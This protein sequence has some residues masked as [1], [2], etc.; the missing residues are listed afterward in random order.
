MQA[1]N[2]L[3]FKGEMRR[4]ALI[5]A[6]ILN[7]FSLSWALDYTFFDVSEAFLKEVNAFRADPVGYAGELGMELE[8]PPYR[9][10]A[11]T[12]NPVL[13]DVAMAHL[14]DM[15]QRQY[16]SHVD[17]DGLTPE[18]RVDEAGV[19]ALM[20]GES[21]G[22]LAF[23]NY[24]SPEEA[25]RLFVYN[26]LSKLKSCESRE[27]APFVFPYTQ[28]GVALMGLRLSINGES[29]NVYVM[30]IDW[31][32]PYESASSWLVGR[33]FEDKNGNFFYDD[34]EE[35]A[36]ASLELRLRK[37]VRSAKTLCD[38]SF[39]FQL[40]SQMALGNL[41]VRYGGV[42]KNRF[43]MANLPCRVDVLWVGGQN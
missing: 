36:G 8:A 43:L 15:V 14:E 25:V 10:P 7:M 28:V 42:S 22:Y 13:N 21:I 20:V 19:K 39:A 27:G 41:K 33:V 3:K 31:V 5:V 2:L 29:F 26:F 23:E 12:I 4:L 1:S 6:I 9:L 17:P 11:L 30:C 16:F 35:I 32:L 37:D 24:I 38:G 40:N 18:D 34:G